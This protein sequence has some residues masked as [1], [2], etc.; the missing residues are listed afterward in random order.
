MKVKKLNT[1]TFISN[2]VFKSD[3]QSGLGSRGH[4]NCYSLGSLL[5]SSL[6]VCKYTLRSS[7]HKC[8]ESQAGSPNEIS[9]LAIRTQAQS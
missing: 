7:K 4:R 3:A 1:F 2:L 5:V 9:R 6:Q 8:P